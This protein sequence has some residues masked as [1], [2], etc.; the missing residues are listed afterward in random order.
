M[1]VFNYDP[2]TLVYTGGTPCDFCQQK[3][4]TIIAPAWS[5]KTPPPREWNNSVNWPHYRPET[6]DWDLRPLPAEPEQEPAQPAEPPPA[7]PIEMLQATLT[8][9]LEAAQRLMDELKKTAGEGA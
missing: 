3:P 9:H 4:G 6:D 2:A 5:T 7:A 1:Y 8:A